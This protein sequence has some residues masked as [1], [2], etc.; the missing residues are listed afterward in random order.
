[1]SI[2]SA[3][4]QRGASFERRGGAEQAFLQVVG[5]DNAAVELYRSVECEMSQRHWY[6][7]GG[8]EGS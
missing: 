7:R 3:L 5:R 2:D 1:M 8:M 4:D 6:R